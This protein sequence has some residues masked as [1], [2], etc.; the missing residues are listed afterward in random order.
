MNPVL[1]EESCPESI[2]HLKI[3]VNLQIY[4]RIVIKLSSSKIENGEKQT[5]SYNTLCSIRKN[6]PLFRLGEF[7]KIA[8]LKSKKCKH[9]TLQAAEGAVHQMFIFYIFSRF[10]AITLSTK[11]YNP[12]LDSLKKDKLHELQKF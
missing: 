6:F 7:V 10:S 4:H 8:H 11:S 2:K 12:A 5:P 9:Y 1:N 3:W